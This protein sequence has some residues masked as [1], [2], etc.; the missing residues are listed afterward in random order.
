MVY[1]PAEIPTG[2][3]GDAQKTWVP[4]LAVMELLHF[5]NTRRGPH[6]MNSKAPS[7]SVFIYMPTIVQSPIIPK[8]R[9]SRF[10]LTTL[11]RLLSTVVDLGRGP[12][13]Q[14]TVCK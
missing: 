3:A 5:A 7:S 2:D 11:G 8:A 1:H 12:V 9:V 10:G 4:V 13:I 14:G 6:E